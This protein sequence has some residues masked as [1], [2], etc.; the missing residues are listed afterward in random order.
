MAALPPAGVD[1][2][3][4][5]F[6]D[7]IRKLNAIEKKNREVF[8]TEFKGT[9]KSFAQ[10]TKAAKNYEKQLKKTSNAQKDAIRETKELASAQ[11][12]SAATQRTATLQTGNAILDVAKQIATVVG[13]TARLAAQF[14]GQ[15]TGLQNLAGSFSQSGSEIQAAIQIASR[16]TI[17]G[18]E[19]IQAANAGLL[20]GVAKTPKEFEKITKVALV[21]GRTLGLTGTQSIEQF[22]TA[23]GRQSLLILDNFG[24]SAK[25]VNAEIDKLAQAEFGKLR[26]GLSAAQRQTLFMQAAL[27]IASESAA[28]IGEEAGK[29]Q[30]AFDALNAVSQDLKVTFGET[31]RPAATAVAE[32]LANAF[33]AGQQAIAIISGAV[34]GVNALLKQLG[35]TFNVIE[36]IRK[37]ARGD[38]TGLTILD[39]NQLKKGIQ[40]FDQT[41]ETATNAAKERFKDVA[42]TIAGVSFD[43]G[44][45]KAMGNAFDDQ[46]EAIDLS[47]DALRN[48]QSIIQQAEQLQLSFTRAAED[49]A[50]KLVRANEDIARKQKRQRDKLLKTQQKQLDSF[51][52]DRRKQITKIES[53]RKQAGVQRK[54]DQEKLQRELRQ[55]QK[56]FNLSRLQSER[57]FS[58]SERR[59]RAEGDILALQQLREDRNLERQEEKESFD[60]GK[61]ETIQSAKEQQ[62]EQSKDLE[63]RISTLKTNL[64]D[65]RATLLKSF[66]EQVIAQQETFAIQAQDRKIALA[67]EEQDRRISQARQLQ[68][69]GISFANQKDITTEGTLKVADEIGK[70]FGQAGV[71]D[72]IITGF[73]T[74]TESDFKKLFD[75]LEN[76]V[77]STRIG[78]ISSGIGRQRIGGIPEF[79]EG[80]IVEGSGPVGSPQLVRA[81]KGET[82][83][84]THQNT[85]QGQFFRNIIQQAERGTME[86]F[87]MSVPVIPSQEVNVT[88]SGGFNITGEEQANEAIL[89][90]AAQEMTDNFRIAVRRLTRRN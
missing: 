49:T 6:N 1:L 32:A 13:E 24:I 64:E 48:Y 8:D 70:I 36:R 31:L 4:K 75:N 71:A 84:P 72:Q 68:D 27:K 80:G 66:D 89:Q 47:T 15:Q 90:A 33:R 28:A 16:G 12:A 22:T 26:T 10:V 50:L 87:Q 43:D 21:L 19:A 57:R 29:S 77:S 69:L 73:T 30:A 2:Q 88:M 58:L 35:I 55:A 34:A 79:G 44:P 39:V 11:K 85:Q 23:L 18:L 56:R 25:Q 78:S 61:K 81:H 51:E 54:R 60:L 62:K 17:S 5:G 42:R 38:L 20:L 41:V 67:R 9:G 76:I 37:I 3:A 52:R 7:Y 53:E 65:Q 63:K 74:R 83:L 46:A 86:S 45:I 14:R 82:F 59:L 40:D